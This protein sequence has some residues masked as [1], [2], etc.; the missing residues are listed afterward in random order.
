MTR[1]R[2]VGVAVLAGLGVAA[3]VVVVAQFDPGRFVY[4]QPLRGAGMLSLAVGVLP[5][6]L[7][8]AVSLNA[9][10]R[11][12]KGLVAGG[13]LA[14]FML[15]MV[16]MCGYPITS[17]RIDDRMDRDVAVV[18]VA[19]DRTFEIVV[20]TRHGDSGDYLILRA[21]SR[22]GVFSRNA[23]YPFAWICDGAGRIEVSFTGAAEVK[24]R[25]GDAFE[26]TVAVNPRTLQAAE[27]ISTCT[28]DHG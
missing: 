4:L 1:Y 2:R 22:D 14:A 20:A 18:A 10:A 23:E 26:G 12:R 8:L 24:V 25:A 17:M 28:G 7:G 5:L 15:G 27:S 19:P 6:L 21:R 9:P 11:H 16:M 13:V 3:V